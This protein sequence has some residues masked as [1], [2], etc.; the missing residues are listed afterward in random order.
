M[1]K[2][3]AYSAV[4]ADK[5]IPDGLSGKRGLIFFLNIMTVAAAAA[6][7]QRQNRDVVGFTVVAH[8]PASMAEQEA[9]DSAEEQA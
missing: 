3:F 4:Y 5:Y 7:L 1:L 8:T 2:F 6:R 9:R